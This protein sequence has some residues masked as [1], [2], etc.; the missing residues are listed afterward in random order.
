MKKKFSIIV[1]LLIVLVP[2]NIKA[3]TGS[4]KITCNKEKVNAGD[5]VTCTIKGNTD[6]EI[7]GVSASLN[8]SDNLVFTSFTKNN[9]WDEGSIENNKLDVYS[10]NY[11]NN[12]F[13]I[14]TMIITAKSNI[15]NTNETITL[16]DITFQNDKS[17]NAEENTFK[18]S[19]SSSKIRIPSKDNL[20]KSLTISNISFSFNENNTNYQLETKETSVTIKATAKDSNAT[21]TG[22][23]GTKN[24]KYG[25]NNFSIQVTSESGDIKIY[26]LN[27]VRPDSR[28]KE[29]YLTGFEFNN[30]DLKFDKDKTDYD[31][32]LENNVS[33]LGIC[34]K[35]DNTLC[36]NLDRIKVS[37][38]STYS[39]K[40][41]DK[42]IDKNSNV[43][44]INIGNNTLQIIVKAEN[45]GE[46]IY[47]FNI[48]RMNEESKPSD[49]KNNN[50]ITNKDKTNDDITNN[51]KTG[52]ALI[53]GISLILILSISVTIVLYRKKIVKDK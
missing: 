27:I 1:L 25:G 23:I 46:R 13:D 38:K 3:A 11:L 19:D 16:K 36:I 39:I 21:V 6:S 7:I 33:K 49:S 40:F 5:S 41:N 8:L 18:V 26:S 15:S 9:S 31:I 52:D 22:D 4:I 48:N 47:T 24:L 17:N 45:D 37:D 30:Y 12:D 35:E 10:E 34:N 29:N 44:N 14:G 2:C 53:I 50:D 43:E 32:T 51:S 28:S 20:L 42:V